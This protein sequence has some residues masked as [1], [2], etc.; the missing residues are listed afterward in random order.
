M[1]VWICSLLLEYLALL[2]IL[3]S[4][5]M[6]QIFE[7]LLHQLLNLSNT[8]WKKMKLMLKGLK[9]MKACKKVSSSNY[10]DKNYNKMFNTN[11]FITK[12]EPSKAVQ[13][14]Q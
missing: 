6:Q 11:N 5:K 4:S 7:F 8:W 3:R 1:Q 12:C 2:F 9:E 10:Y 14:T 13:Q